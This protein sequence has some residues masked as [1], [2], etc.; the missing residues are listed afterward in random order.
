[1][2]SETAEKAT[3]VLGRLS[4]CRRK[5][6]DAFGKGNEFSQRPNLH[7]LHHPVAM[8]L[9]RALGR[10]QGVGDPLVGLAANDL[11]QRL[12]ARAAS[13]PRYVSERRSACSSGSVVNKRL[14][15]SSGI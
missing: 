5:N 8:G 10:A 11:V 7:F 3:V 9:D 6:A 15:Q 14:A 4:G 1:M 13:M 2:D 12:A